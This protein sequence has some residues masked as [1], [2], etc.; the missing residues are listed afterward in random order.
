[1]FF[2]TIVNQSQL[3]NFHKRKA[4]KYCFKYFITNKNEK[5]KFVIKMCHD[6]T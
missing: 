4:S 6:N 1:M 5:N 3:N 2:D